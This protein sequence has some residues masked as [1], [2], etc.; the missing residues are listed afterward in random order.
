[1]IIASRREDVTEVVCC[2]A[3]QTKRGR[4]A[5]DCCR[6]KCERRRLVLLVSREL[7]ATVTRTISNRSRRKIDEPYMRSYMAT[8]LLE[9]TLSRKHSASLHIRTTHED[10]RD[11]TPSNTRHKARDTIRLLTGAMHSLLTHSLL[12]Y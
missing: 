1:M 5:S 4:T 8:F 3:W 9:M 11:K 7:I 2:P 12:D 6:T 10:G